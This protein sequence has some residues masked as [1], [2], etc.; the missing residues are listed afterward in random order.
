MKPKFYRKVLKNGMTVIL[1]KRS[2]PVISLAFVVKT[3]A[4]HEKEKE[5]GISHFIEHM[6]FKG[7]KTR[8]SK[9]IAQEIEK[10]GGEING[11]TDETITAY[12]CK[13]P[14]K[15]LKSA[16]NVFSDLVKNPLFDEKETEKER[17]VIFEE[18]KM[19]KDN[20]RYHVFN[21]LKS[22][23]YKKPFGMNI[24]GNFETVKNISRADL[25]KKFKEIYSPENM[26]L[27]VVGD[28]DFMELVSFAEKNFIKGTLR[29]TSP[30]I[31]KKIASSIEERE[32]ID[33][34]NLVLGYHVPNSTSKK[35][36]A[37]EVLNFIMAG[38][39]SSRLWGEIREKR[40]LVYAIKG[41]SEVTKLFGYNFIY[42]GA[43]KEN[44][45]LIKKLIL[46]EF[47]KVID[48]LDKKELD[49]VKEQI[50][51]NHYIALEDSQMQMIN[52]IYY[53]IDGNAQNFYGFEKHISAVTIQEVKEIAKN[54]IKNH[55]FVA[56]VPK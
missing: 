44:V 27:C 37:A 13:T 49:E 36:Y 42:A 15:H 18:I 52:L 47:Q 43:N 8:D 46:E 45:G 40:N 50:I 9:K 10:K 29:I 3:G 51:G 38:G 6:L 39:M 4:L 33:Q 16:L 32:G 7:T 20:P 11:F 28:A 24:A 14:S 41:D 34:A 35:S 5:K 12:W 31:I 22:H 48:S 56:L 55:S 21:E 25:A 54:A 19:Y 53:E 1:E 2:L 17:Q 23:L 26:I 30:K